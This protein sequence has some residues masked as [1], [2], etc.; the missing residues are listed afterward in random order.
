MGDGA[1]SIGCVDVA[2]RTL[3]D[4]QG[5]AELFGASL[6]LE[7]AGS[8]GWRRPRRS[9]WSAGSSSEATATALSAI[10][11]S[12]CGCCRRARAPA[13]SRLLLLRTTYAGRPERHGAPQSAA[14]RTAGSRTRR[15]S[16]RPLAEIYRQQPIYY[17]SNRF[18]VV[19]PIADVALA[20]LFQLSRLRTRDRH[21][22]RPRPAGTFRATG[23]RRTSSATRSSTISRRATARRARWRAG[24]GRPR[25]RASIAA[26]PS[27]PGS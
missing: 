16:D 8:H 12:P 2:G 15:S 6:L 18:N 19:G 3:L 25:A 24:W 5:L 22:H 17:L 9:I 20:A 10:H 13:D 7:S 4:L 21:L 11:S 27:V 14:R 23:P 1:A 26:T